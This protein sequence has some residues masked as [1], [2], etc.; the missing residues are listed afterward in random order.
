[1]AGF[2]FV[3]EVNEKYALMLQELRDV[4]KSFPK[5]DPK[6][7]YFYNVA[8]KSLKNFTRDYIEYKDRECKEIDVLALAHMVYGW[9]P[10]ILNVDK[11]NTE[12]DE[13]SDEVWFEKFNDAVENFKLNFNEIRTVKENF[14]DEKF[15][16]RLQSIIE[17][18]KIITNNSVIGASKLLHFINPSF[19]PIYDSRVFH[20]IRKLYFRVNECDCKSA[21]NKKEDWNTVDNIRKYNSYI[22][23]ILRWCNNKEALIEIRD[24]LNKEKYIDDDATDIRVFEV[25]LF[26]Y[27]RGKSD[28]F[29]D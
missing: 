23:M 13:Q 16:Q 4:V 27:G 1:M 10:T 29:A 14:G 8:Y 24:K 9:M 22:A 3:N 26:V 15:Q 12:Q 17:N 6:S 11:I 5:M 20:A 2:S 7:Y 19:F 28:K 25:A 18:T 21:E